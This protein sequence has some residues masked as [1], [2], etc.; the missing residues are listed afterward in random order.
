MRTRSPIPVNRLDNPLDIDREIF[1]KD[2]Q[3]TED[4]HL[5]LSE[6]YMYYKDLADRCLINPS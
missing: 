1:K 3:R 2:D 5:K 4:L 6:N